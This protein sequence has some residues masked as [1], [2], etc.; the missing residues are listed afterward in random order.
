MLALPL[1]GCGREAPRRAQR[2]PI[3]VAPVE[4]KTIPLEIAATGTVEPIQSA[5]VAARVSGLLTRVSFREGSEVAKGQVLFEIDPRTFQAA[6]ERA[7]AVLE[8]D[9]AQ[10]RS[11]ALDYSRAQTLAERGLVAAVELD[12][13]RADAEALHAAVR[14]DSA[15]LESAKLDLAHATVRAP[16]AGRTGSLNVHAGDL[17]REDD[18]NAPLVTINQLRPIL[19]RFTVPQSDLG[20]LR[21]RRTAG[22]RASVATGEDSTWIDGKLVFVDN[23]VDVASGTLLLK[24]EF[25]NQ[26]AGLWP[27]EFVRVRLTLA[28]EADVTVVPA[29]AVTNS[30]QGT[31]CYVVQPDTTVEA[32]PVTVARTWGDW[33]VVASGLAPGE[34]VVTDGQLRLGPGARGVI[35]AT[36]DTG[37][38]G[39]AGGGTA[40]GTQAS[41]A[42][43]DPA[44]GSAR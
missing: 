36:P 29:V 44:G 27:G 35:R 7:A 14:A 19:V 43:A 41:P 31:Y 12:Q 6:A 13:K 22:L 32:R 33:A 17:V 30:Q 8:R 15:A 3:S 20:D 2:I 23:A 24:A 16:I 18:P 38:A 42:A 9:R 39:G 10:Y 21:R 40:G 37:T 26:N 4:R 28:E 34:I 25:Q 5:G 1:G 11:A